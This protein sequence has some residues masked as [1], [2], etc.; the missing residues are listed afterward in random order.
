LAKQSGLNH[1]VAISASGNY[2]YAS[3]E[4]DVY[5]WKYTSGN[6]TSLGTG[7]HV[8]SNLPCC[9]HETRTLLFSPDESQLYVQSG[10]GSNNDPDATHAEI[11]RWNVTSLSATAPVDWS[12]GQLLAW[13]MRNEVGIR[14][15]TSG[16]LWGVENG[17]DDVA[18]P[19]WA[20]GDIHNDNP[21]E[22]LNRFDVAN[23]G[24]F[25]GYPYCWSEGILP[26]PPGLGATTQW[27]HSD[28]AGKAPYSDA[29]CHNTS[30]VVP[31]VH[32]L[33]A[34]N[35]PLDILFGNITDASAYDQT[36]YV[37]AHGSWDRDI[38][39]GYRVYS[40]TWKGGVVNHA[41]FLQYAGPGATG[42]GWPRPVGLGI[43]PCPW[44]SCLLISSDSNNEIIA[45]GYNVK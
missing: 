27:L 42:S 7:E 23:P 12:T 9:H 8:I 43:I 14:F 32:C 3:S 34:H 19:D 13:G 1:G 4:T 37:A 33:P 2:L 44:G 26:K 30:N 5:R 35:A 39:D 22:E 20:I 10:S 29:W 17:V 36:A 25:Y 11:R 21:C 28:F 16:V 15:D 6:R 40:V 24:K 41:S 18:R 38:P 45:V 31:P